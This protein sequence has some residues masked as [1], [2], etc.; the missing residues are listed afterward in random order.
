MM[1]WFYAYEPPHLG[2]RLIA[3]FQGERADV[4]K[5]FG[6]CAAIEANG[7]VTFWRRP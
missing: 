3:K 7:V 6:R 4:V 5:A 2:G 1:E